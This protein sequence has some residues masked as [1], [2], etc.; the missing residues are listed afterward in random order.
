M[1]RFTDRQL[2]FQLQMVVRT[3]EPAHLVSEMPDDPSGYWDQTRWPLAAWKTKDKW[4]Y[5]KDLLHRHRGEVREIWGQWELVREP[6]PEGP[7]GGFSTTP[8]FP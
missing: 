4:T 1:K 3:E 8:S 6:F 5:V 2:V 7:R